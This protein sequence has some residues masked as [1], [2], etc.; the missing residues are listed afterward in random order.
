[1][2]SKKRQKDMIPEDNPPGPKMSSML[3]RRAITNSSRKNGAARLKQKLRALKAP[4]R[5]LDFK[6]C[7]MGS[8]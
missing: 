3:L 1:M 5:I 8:Y 6:L 7:V 2:N 4:Q